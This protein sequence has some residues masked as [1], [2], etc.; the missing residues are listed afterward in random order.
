MSEPKTEKTRGMNDLTVGNV[1]VK[2]IA[3]AIPI[4]VT[5]LLQA[6]YNI[7]DMAIIGR[8][9][10]SAGMSAVNIGGQVTMI[11]LVFAIGVSNGG[12]IIIGQ[13]FGSG[14]KD[15]IPSVV[16]TMLSF[17]FLMGLFFIVLILVLGVPILKGL[18]TPPEAY[19]GTKTYLFICIA[20]TIFIY[21]YNVLAAV[22]RSVGESVRP[23]LFVLITVILN[24]GLDILFVG[25][26]HMGVAGAALA[27]ILS[28]FI[29]MC[30]AIWYVK[31]IGLFDFRIKSFRIEKDTLKLMLKIGIP[32][33]LQFGL[34]N[35]SFLLIMGFIN[36]YG[37][38]ASAATGAVTKIGTFAVL[39]A[40]ALM[41]AL[42][43]FTAQHIPQQKFKRVIQSMLVAMAISLCFTGL[44]FLL[45]H[46]IPDIML[47]IF[48]TDTA[49]I[50]TGADYL[51]ILTI[52][53]MIESVMFCMYGVISGSG[54]TY[55]TF[56]CAILS[57]FI[58]RLLFTWI[59]TSFTSMGLLG[60]GWA[61]VMA[62]AASGIAAAIFLLTGKWKKSKMKIG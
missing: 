56:G 59:F 53:D 20:G 24:I 18:D 51:K 23:M 43:S 6:L 36:Q 1:A 62:P 55:Y 30:M 54:N 38:N 48:T 22:L 29:S 12:G 14:K 35:I 60:I 44:I 58:V 41:T 32:N 10:G 28:Q 4:I 16:G 33:G 61:Y 7:A 45:A 25:P 52:S 13:L 50:Q 17:F 46:T 27:T 47:G 5:N 9:I 42:I 15:K 19:E 31:K 57:A 2:T 34:T 8:Y 39:P 21:F 37:V 3:F 26:L 49:V 11:I 40:Q